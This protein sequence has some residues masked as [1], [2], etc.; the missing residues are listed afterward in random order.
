MKIL[1]TSDLHGDFETLKHLSDAATDFDAVVV[2]GDLTNFTSSKVAMQMIG[3]ITSNVKNFLIVPGNCDL[4]ETADLYS[5]LGISLHGKGKVIGEIGFFGVGGS[6]I[7]P[8]KTPL[9]YSEDYI[10]EK[11]KEGY[12]SVKDAKIKVL[13]SHAPP[14]ESLDKTSKGHSVGSKAVSEF[15]NE[16]MVDLVIC[17]HVHEGK[18]STKVGETVVINTG[19]TYYGY[20]NVKI[21]G[22]RKISFKF[23]E[24]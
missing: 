17:G 1:C 15:L 7:T 6:N 13:V 2:A 11:L 21:A 9:E 10:L 24:F 4:Q 3:E 23:A 16:N 19:P 22:D 8:F 5:D 12:E 18:G 20:A 14:H